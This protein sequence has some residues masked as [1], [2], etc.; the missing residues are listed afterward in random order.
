MNPILKSIVSVMD[1]IYILLFVRIFA[2]KKFDTKRVLSC[3]CIMG[4]SIVFMTLYFEREYTKNAYLTFFFITFTLV[5]YPVIINKFLK[6]HIFKGMIALLAFAAVDWLVGITVM[7][8]G[9]FIYGNNFMAISHSSISLQIVFCSIQEAADLLAIICFWKL[10]KIYTNRTVFNKKYELAI[11]LYG[12]SMISALIIN[13]VI[14]QNARL[15]TSEMVLTVVTTFIF[16]L[17]NVGF[18]LFVR[19]LAKKEE[20]LAYQEMYNKTLHSI[21][22][23]LSEFK[24]NYDNTIASICG[25]IEFGEQESLL[26]FMNEIKNKHTT[27]RIS[28][29]VM[30]KRIQEPG[31]IGLILDKLKRMRK[32]SILCSVTVE[33]EIDIKG[34]K[35]SD[36]SDCL[37]I[38]IDN[39]IEAVSEMNDGLIAIRARKVEKALVFSIENTVVLPV[40]ID[41]MF[42]KGWS[43]KGDG[44]G[45]GLWSV[46][47]IVNSYKNVFLNTSLKENILCQELIVTF[48]S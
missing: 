40:S 8:F 6:V 45:L 23:Q 16:F 41:R 15:S 48:N 2:G 13:I 26:N 42:E 31:I 1:I 25:Y 35:I 29:I 7:A 27:V 3:L 46:M 37:G 17:M 32:G 19:R 28:N 39:A 11:I 10:L 43:T 20:E 34:I 14:A 38:L 21:V 44:R 24:H 9:S 5:V 30:L 18:V 12:F 4:L 47:N 22:T 33:E 36:L